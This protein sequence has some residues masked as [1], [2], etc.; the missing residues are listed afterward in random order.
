MNRTAVGGL[1]AGAFAVGLLVGLL[2]PVAVGR[3][4]PH[5]P[6][7]DHMSA[8]GS[9]MHAGTM[10]DGGAMPM[11]PLGLRHPGHQFHHPSPGALR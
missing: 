10:M 9:M 1:A 2:A 4:Q 11:S 6:M 7:V 3:P 5:Q 8:M